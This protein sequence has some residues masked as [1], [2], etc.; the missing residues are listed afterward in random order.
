MITE[1]KLKVQPLIGLGLFLMI[2]IFG[3]LKG[4]IN[5]Q[6]TLFLMTGL[7]LGYILTRSRFGFAGGIKRQYITGEGSLGKALLVMFA[8]SMVL[9]AVIQFSAAMNGTPIPGL[10]SVKFLNISILLGG[11]IFGIGMMLAGGCASG[12]LSDAGEG[13]GRAIIALV[14][15]VLGSI[16]GVIAQDKLNA[17]A[18]GQIGIKM[19]LPDVIGYL[20]AIALSFLLLFGL[21]LIVRKYENFRKKEGYFQET[22]YE[23]Q[24]LPMKQ[25]HFKLFSYPTFHKVFV[26]RWSF[27]I[28]GILIA[29][30]FAFIL[31]T[32]GHSWGVTGPFTT[33]GVAF[34][35]M[36]GIEFASPAFADNVAAANNG[37]LND[38]GSLRDFGIIF[39]AAIAFLFAS[40]FTLNFKFKLKDVFYYLVGGLMMGFGARLAGGC[41]I[42]ALFSGISNF[43]LSGWGFFITLAMGGIFALKV[44]AG[45]VDIIPPDRH[46][47]AS[48]TGKEKRKESFAFEEK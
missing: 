6:L 2:A 40:R 23:D 38:P 14:A 29:I 18:I 12:T 10:S 4:G 3:I 26:Q 5:Q 16:P 30:M 39:G 13:E 15:F 32:T 11:F 47:K 46:Q 37:I 21:Y 44:F 45:S 28:G 31:I 25:E 17:S 41:N 42:G 7:A 9:A 19:Y 43:S 20:G 35:Q 1:S 34:F 33:W 48:E 22:V 8:L 24:E 27:M 36:F